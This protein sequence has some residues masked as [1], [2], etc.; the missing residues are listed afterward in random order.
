LEHGVH[1]EEPVAL[2]YVPFAQGWQA[3]VVPVLNLPFSQIAQIA[4]GYGTPDPAAQG[5]CVLQ[6]PVVSSDQPSE[7][8]QVPFPALPLAQVP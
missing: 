6:P 4:P 2:A 7:Q 5:S 3:P 1:A 8:E